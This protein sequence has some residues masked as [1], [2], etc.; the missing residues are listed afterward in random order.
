MLNETVLH[1][2][3]PSQLINFRTFAFSFFIFTAVAY[4]FTLK[5]YN[6]INGTHFSGHLDSLLLIVAIFSMLNG[7]YAYLTIKTTIYTITDHRIIKSFGLFNKETIDCV[8][9]RVREVQLF[10]PFVYRLFR[11]GNVQLISSQHEARVIHL[12][13]IKNASRIKE[14][15]GTLIELRRADRGINE[16]DTY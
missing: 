7:L 6:E 5:N 2:I 4:L 8:L 12:I 1:E 10:E 3:K 9:Y 16:L 13:A 14:E 15:L 11:I